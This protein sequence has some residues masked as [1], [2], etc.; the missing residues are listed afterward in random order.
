MQIINTKVI[1]TV[2]ISLRFLSQYKLSGGL[3]YL[4]N[5]LYVANWPYNFPDIQDWK[6]W[7]L[8]IEINV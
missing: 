7:L 6:V 3:L 4:D 2:P 8:M 5:N 1:I